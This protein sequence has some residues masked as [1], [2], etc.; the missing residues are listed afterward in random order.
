MKTEEKLIERVKELTCLYEVSKIISHSNSVDLKV[1][2]KIILSIKNAWKHSDDAT[3]E[4]QIL[5]HYITTSKLPKSTVFQISLINIPE[6]NPGYIKVHYPQNKFKHNQF[7]TDEQKLL[8]TLAIEIANYIEKYHTLEKKAA[9]RRTIE[10]MNRLYILGEMTTG[11]AHELNNP[12]ANILGYAELIKLNNNDPENDADIT[13]IINSVIYTREIVKKIMLFSREMP[14][15]TQY[16]TIKPIITFA[17]SFLKPNFQK[18]EIKSELLF[19]NDDITAKVDSVQLTQILFN[20]L[21]NAIHASPQ[22]STI[23]TTIETDKENLII[24][25]EDQGSGIPDDLKHKIFEPF[26]TTKDA[27]I[28]YGLGLSVIQNIV[29]KHN[30][31]IIVQ[32]NFPTGTIFIIKLPL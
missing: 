24:K 5:D 9:L 10:R 27:N 17:L 11:I 7:L 1:L 3:V 16:V 31:E 14:H 28:G 22:N 25:I 19:Q 6:A 8:N 15:Q 26:F 32:N 29:K 13:T 30:G 23:R 4:I 18:K 2:K 12:L 20:I 21:I